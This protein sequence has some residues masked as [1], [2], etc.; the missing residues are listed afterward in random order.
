MKK[1]L[2]LFFC[3]ILL[4]CGGSDIESE[5][6]SGISENDS[7]VYEKTYSIIGNS[8]ST[9]NGYIPG[10]YAT[11]YPKVWFKGVDDTWWMII[12]RLLNLHFLSNASWSA[13]TVS[14]NK[15]SCFTSDIRL[16]HLSAS[17]IP[18]IIFIAGGT[19][20]WVAGV[21][22]GEENDELN[23]NTST[24]RGAYALM[25]NKLK[26][27]Y[28]KTE[29]VCLGIFPRS[30]GFDTPNKK[31]WTVRE[32]NH[33]IDLL[34]QKNEYRYIDMELC[35]IADDFKKYTHDGLHPTYEGMKLIANHIQKKYLLLSN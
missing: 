17:G 13:S 7:L 9:Y 24:F 21:S 20:D 5:I 30:D 31:G 35:G 16:K 3:I 14:G 2:F 8:I 11:Y 29:V 28:P 26:T 33:F 23:Y 18:E 6:Q 22:L 19:N 1:I 4:S 34:A 10:D 25:L 15:Q 27:M 32:A 12:G